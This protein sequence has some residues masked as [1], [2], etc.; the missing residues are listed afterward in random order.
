[1]LHVC[2]SKIAMACQVSPVKHQIQNENLHLETIEQTCSPIFTMQFFIF[3]EENS[4]K[5]CD[6]D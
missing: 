3:S 5:I 1:M 2:E 4:R 6:D